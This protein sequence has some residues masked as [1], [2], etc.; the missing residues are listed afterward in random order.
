MA[1]TFDNLATTF[2][3]NLTT[4]DSDEVITGGGFLPSARNRTKE[5]IEAERLRLG[6]IKRKKKIKEIKKVVSTTKKKVEVKD[7]VIT[8]PLLQQRQ[9]IEA[10]MLQQQLEQEAMQRE[11]EAYTALLL[12]IQLQ[13]KQQEQQ[14]AYEQALLE[15]EQAELEAQAE[16]ERLERLRLEEEAEVVQILKILAKQMRK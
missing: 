16:F 15:Q 8:M 11:Q 9:Q 7:N 14:Q 3:A 13:V 10:L 4:F 1:T 2:D 6:I 12:Q 5:E